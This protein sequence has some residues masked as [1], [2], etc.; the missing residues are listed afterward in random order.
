MHFLALF[1]IVQKLLLI[2]GKCTNI[3]YEVDTV[4]PEVSKLTYFDY[5]TYYTTSASGDI[6]LQVKEAP[7][8]GLAPYLQVIPDDG[9]FTDFESIL[10]YDGLTANLANNVKANLKFRLQL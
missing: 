3:N 10:I 2:Y 8:A 9:E 5:Y 6:V 7:P 4:R 1:L